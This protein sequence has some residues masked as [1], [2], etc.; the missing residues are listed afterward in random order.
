MIRHY[1]VPTLI[2]APKAVCLY[3][4]PDEIDRWSR[5]T[6]YSL[7]LGSR[8]NRERSYNTQADIHIINY[9]NLA[10]L[11]STFPWKW[12]LVI[13]DEASNMKSNGVRNKAFRRVRD[14]V[15]KV[16]MMS[17]TP[18][19]DDPQGLFWQ[20]LCLDGGKTFGRT[21]SD[22]R[23]RY[24][25]NRNPHFPDWRLRPGAAEEIRKKLNSTMLVLRAR[26]YIKDLPKLV[27]AHHP[28]ELSPAGQDQ[29]HQMMRTQVLELGSEEAIL[30]ATAAVKSNKLRQICSGFVYNDEGKAK[31]LAKDKF[32][33]YQR[34]LAELGE[35][36]Q[37]M[38][39]YYFQ[40]EKKILPGEPLN[41]HN[42]TLWN[43][44]R[45]K[46][47]KLH[48]ASG[49]HGLNLQHS[50]AKHI[51]FYTTPWSGEEYRQAIGRVLR[52]GNQAEVV[53]V[54]HMLAMGTIEERVLRQ[55]KTK[56]ETEFQLI[57]G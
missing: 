30:A 22:F 29:Y 19:A 54:H 8:D 40:P 18:A 27:V 42:K 3:T 32:E 46:R 9:D 12:Q 16:I 55:H 25:V 24:M 51:V 39:F 4:W 28:F 47:L 17:G 34:L 15:W 45:L 41:D 21:I 5:G 23:N 33:A 53:F 56:M 37:V 20:Y 26:D 2:V 31:L 57:G 36:E 10:W 44:G 13:F 48:C 11:I 35:D 6:T 49:A 50:N 14:Q 7:M 38:T 43:S 52:S 1:N